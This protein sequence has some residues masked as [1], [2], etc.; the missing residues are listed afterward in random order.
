MEKK[1]DKNIYDCP[2]CG[3]H[4]VKVHSVKDRENQIY[5]AT[6]RFCKARGPIRKSPDKALVEWT[7]VGDIVRKYYDGADEQD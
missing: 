3:S 6:C 5:F 4:D 1:R 7:E 2:F